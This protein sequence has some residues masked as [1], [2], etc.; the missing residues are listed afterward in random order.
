MNRL[1]SCVG[2]IL[3]LMPARLWSCDCGLSPACA[4]VGADVIFLGRV[5]FTNHDNS[6]GLNQATLV[7]F[8]VEERFS[9]LAPDVRQVWVDPGSFTS[10]YAEYQP[11][12]RY[13][14]FATRGP[15]VPQSTAAMTIVSGRGSKP[16]QLPPEFYTAVPPPIYY[17]PECVG[18]R[19]ATGTPGFA[20]DLA[21]LRQ[22][23]DG[24]PPPRVLGHVHLKPFLG[25][26]MLNGPA[27][28][29][30]AITISNGPVTLKTTSDRTGRFSL[31]DAPPGDY[32]VRAELAPYRT[33]EDVLDP[34]TGSPPGRVLIAARGCGYTEIQ[35]ETT[36]TIR[37]VV[38]DH[39]GRA[40]PHIPV[41]GR[42]KEKTDDEA[43]ALF[44]TTD[45][46]GQFTISG[47]PDAEIYLWAGSEA[48]SLSMR[49]RRVF[50]PTGNDRENARTI[51][52]KPGESR[53]SIVLRVDAPLKKGRVEVHVINAAGQAVGNAS[54]NLYGGDV[55]HGHHYNIARTSGRGTTEY[56]CLRGQRYELEAAAEQ[57]QGG[58]RRVLA[59]SRVPFTCGD[60]REPTVLVLNRPY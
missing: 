40:A 57:W 19:L 28:D 16:K 51:R 23:R 43:F 55:S 8:D 6:V 21:M 7:R 14:V 53:E 52:L 58:K 5:T 36:S 11:N 25:W 26:P 60:Q 42:L 22:Q 9:G 32:T 3:A 45:A 46:K 10:C 24:I 41:V 59:S 56:P 44:A 13:L 30:V 18:S 29:G 48:P 1:F 47:V 31:Q 37:G 20:Q 34:H 49:Y 15:E 50:Y 2:I 27:L 33:S 54:V 39:A 35:M 4:Y 12:G 38:L 17:S